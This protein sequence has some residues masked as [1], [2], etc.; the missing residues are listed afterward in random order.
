[1]NLHVHSFAFGL[2]VEVTITRSGELGKVVSAAKHLR[3]TEAQYLV[4][5]KAADGRA[6]ESWF[7]ES[8]LVG[9]AS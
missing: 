6:A 1:M 5:Y 9:A 4:E 2:G 3:H 7:Y 8:E